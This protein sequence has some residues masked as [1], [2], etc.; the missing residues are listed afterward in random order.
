[1]VHH[2]NR[3]MQLAK[4]RGYNKSSLGRLLGKS[5]QSV[6]YDIKREF[7]NAETLQK[8]ADFLQ[9]NLSEFEKNIESNSFNENWKDKYFESLEVINRLLTV[10]NQNGIKVD[11]GKF[12]VSNLH[13]VRNIFFVP[14]YSI[15]NI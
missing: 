15:A 1:M 8:Y 9:V 11:L 10:I 13:P 12:R 7:L 3:I 4:S 6:D 5:H 2:G 14:A